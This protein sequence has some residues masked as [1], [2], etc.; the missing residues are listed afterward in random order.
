MP[1]FSLEDCTPINGDSIDQAVTW[2][3]GDLK[4]LAGTSVRLRF[5]L[6]EADL[7]SLKFS[8]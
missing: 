7:Y 3:G 4:S 1:G 6:K 2:K 8:E 5:A